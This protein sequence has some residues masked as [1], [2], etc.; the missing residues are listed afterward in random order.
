MH[1]LPPDS[2]DCSELGAPESG[3][4]VAAS[5]PDDVLPASFPLPLAF[6]LDPD[7]DEPLPDDEFD[8]PA[9]PE[10]DPEEPPLAPEDD[11]PS[12]RDA[13]PPSRGDDPPSARDV[14]PA[15]P[16]EVAPLPDPPATGVPPSALAQ[17]GKA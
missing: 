8:D 15:S 10:D 13:A 1:D 12:A 5:S 4:A 3:S 16:G 11:P 7:E 17:A 14:E 9:E 6:V 2:V